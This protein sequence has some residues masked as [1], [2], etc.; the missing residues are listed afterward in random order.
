MT[1]ILDLKVGS[2]CTSNEAYV[3]CSLLT[4]H[5]IIVLSPPPIMPLVK[6]D[7]I[8]GVRT[9]AQVKSLA[10]TIQ[11]TLME[12][13]AAPPRDRYQ[14]ITQHE[15]YEMICEDTALGYKR[16]ERLVFVHVFQQ[17][18]TAEQKQTFYQKLMEGLAKTDSL[19]KED[20]IVSMAKNEKE[21][22]SFGEGRAQFLDGGLPIKK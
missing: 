17:G 7:I 22:W 2:I 6:I 21:D 15:P 5:Y 8:R 9:P 19:G 18:R 12:H 3:C 1:K 13:F 11:S 16:T 4:L 10:D 14:I 20:L